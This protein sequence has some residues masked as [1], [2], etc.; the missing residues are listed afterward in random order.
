MEKILLSTKTTATMNR[1]NN[2]IKGVLSLS[3]ALLFTTIAQSQEVLKRK[4]IDSLTKQ[5]L[6]AYEHAIQILN[7]RSVKNVYDQDGYAWQAWVHNKSFVKVS[8]KPSRP[9]GP[10]ESLT[11][12][13]KAMLIASG[14]DAVPGYPGECEHGKDLFLFWHRAELYYFE[15][16]LQGADPAGTVTDSKGHTGPSTVKVTIPY[17]NFTQPASGVG[18]RFPKA[19]ENKESILY[20]EGRGS[21]IPSYPYTNKSM[22][23]DKINNN[24]VVFGGFPN[25]VG[26]GARFRGFGLFEAEI[27]NPMHATYCAGEMADNSTAAY[28]PIFFSF[29]NYLDY[30][31]DEW[32][33]LNNMETTGVNE[34]DTITSLNYHLRG[35]LSAKYNLPNYDPGKGNRPTMSKCSLYLNHADLGY[36]YEVS[37]EDRYQPRSAPIALLTDK[38]GQSVVFG[39]SEKSP[40]SLLTANTLLAPEAKEGIKQAAGSL[41]NSKI[42][43]QD[44]YLNYETSVRKSFKVDVYIHP[45]NIKAAIANKAFRNKY[46]ACSSTYWKLD[47]DNESHGTEAGKTKLNIYIAEALKDIRKNYNPADWVVTTNLTQL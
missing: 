41:T 44:G 33:R 22:I 32:L 11:D 35:Q 8:K 34:K 13:Y 3:I 43:I 17:W 18:K 39:R 46:L 45:K 29:H 36:E 20:H 2:I 7:D 25:S 9:I 16:V 26:N 42:P 14:P 28:D 23:Q 19:F 4:N 37:P 30:V 1:Q 21:G 6:A 47:H 38:N 5:E 27:H 15:K 31:F 40:Q 12:Y 24:W 10:N